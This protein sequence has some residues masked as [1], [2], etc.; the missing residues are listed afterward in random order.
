MPT[1]PCSGSPFYWHGVTRKRC[2]GQTKTLQRWVFLPMHPIDKYAA[3]HHKGE[4]T[5]HHCKVLLVI[6]TATCCTSDGTP[7]YLSTEQNQARVSSSVRVVLANLVKCCILLSDAKVEATGANAHNHRRSGKVIISAFTLSGGDSCHVHRHSGPAN[8]LQLPSLTVRRLPHA[9]GT[10][11]CRGRSFPRRARTA[12]VGHR[13]PNRWQPLQLELF[14][15]GQAVADPSP[16]R[17]G[18]SCMGGMPEHARDRTRSEMRL[19]RGM[20]ASGNRSAGG[21]PHRTAQA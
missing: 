21:E 16:S 3:V 8:L 11:K 19:R 14:Q 4:D 1:N 15:V 7:F 10:D 12:L 20:G 6:K 18:A 9:G 17:G 2:I 5:T 13:R